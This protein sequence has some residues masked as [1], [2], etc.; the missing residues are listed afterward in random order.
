MS[1]S[2]NDFNIQSESNTL[3]VLHGEACDVL[4][5]ALCKLIQ[6]RTIK[7]CGQSIKRFQGGTKC[8]RHSAASKSQ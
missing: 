4:C 5:A 8:K 1:Q 6:C 3:S 2:L 7:S